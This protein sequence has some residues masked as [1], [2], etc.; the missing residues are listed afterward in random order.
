MS[1][2]ARTVETKPTFGK[3]E[4]WAPGAYSIDFAAV[5]D[6]PVKDNEHSSTFGEVYCKLVGSKIEQMP[7]RFSHKDKYTTDKG[8]VELDCEW[9][10]A[11]TMRKL[12]DL[13]R[14]GIDPHRV[15]WFYY[16]HDW[17][18][19]ADESYTFFAVCDGKII[20]E[21][22][23]FNAL[24]PLIL[25]RQQ[26]DDPIWHSHPHLDAAWESYLYRKFY[27]ETVTGQL[28]VLRPDEPILYHFERPSRDKLRD[29]E[30]VT[31]VKIYRLLWVAIPMLVAIVFPSIKLYMAGLAGLLMIDV[32]WRAWATR[33]LE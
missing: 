25:K 13:N 31:L 6:I 1:E 15:T 30:L 22:S 16:D 29:L 3:F 8:E 20:D 32:L 18:R 2:A 11:S 4:S 17:S 33:N 14:Q 27:T 24:E 21:S 10:I 28:T 5:R 9:P 26:D 12:I 19:D 7:D 23:R